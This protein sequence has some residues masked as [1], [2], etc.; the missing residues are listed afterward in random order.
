[1]NRRARGRHADRDAIPVA[2]HDHADMHRLAA[3]CL[4]DT[5]FVFEVGARETAERAMLT[6]PVRE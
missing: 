5:H 2:D 3:W 4:L 1:M 6:L